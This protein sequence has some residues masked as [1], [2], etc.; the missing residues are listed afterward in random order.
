MAGA[1][2]LTMRGYRY[3]RRVDFKVRICY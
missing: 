1:I 2:R 3:M